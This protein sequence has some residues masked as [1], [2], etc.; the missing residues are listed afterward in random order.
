MGLAQPV[1][2]VR[3]LTRLLTDKIE[4]IAPGFGIDR[5]TLLERFQHAPHG[6][7]RAVQAHG[8]VA[9]LR[10]VAALLADAV[11]QHAVL[12]AVQP[13][14]QSVAA[15][16][17]RVGEACG[18][19]LQQTHRRIGRCAGDHRA[20]RRFQRAQRLPSRGDQQASG[21]GEMQP[22]DAVVAA[23]LAF[24]RRIDAALV[25]PV[26]EHA[27]RHRVF[28]LQVDVCVGRKERRLRLLG[29]RQQRDD[30][31]TADIAQVQVQPVPVIAGRLPQR[32]RIV[33]GRIARM[34]ASVAIEPV[35]P[36][37][38]GPSGG[39]RQGGCVIERGGHA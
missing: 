3:R 2:D 15:A 8:L 31:R 10:Q 1:R 12:D 7:E 37:R 33:G 28:E 30:L 4:T 13:H 36:E 21:H 16:F 27:V 6:G 17:H 32:A 14:G 38:G 29:E 39:R 26:D 19:H 24:G 20:A 18:H 22:A 34:G 11:R 35:Q 5:M 23:Q 9:Q 25:H